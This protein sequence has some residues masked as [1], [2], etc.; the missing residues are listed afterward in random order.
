MDAMQDQLT[1]HLDL[2]SLNGFLALEPTLDL[3]EEMVVPA[4]WLP[5]S[6]ILGR[7]SS[8]QPNA[9][10]DDPLAQYKARRASARSQFEQREHH[11]NCQRLG[12]TE[13]Q[14]ARNF[15]A[16]QVHI[17]LLYVNQLDIDPR[18]Y[19]RGVYQAVFVQDKSLQTP[20]EVAELLQ[21][22][23]IDA[24]GIMDYLK[25]GQAAL[26]EL[27]ERLL[28]Q[29]IFDSPAYLYRGERYHGRQHLPLLRWYVEG[30]KGTPPV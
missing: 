21:V 5:V 2:S 6:G 16:E 27:Q 4:R 19:I 8:Q 14:G 30:S 26:S 29:G 20:D 17:G 7:L 11:R 22:L 12:I 1:I 28:E 15:D 25:V 13:E 24:A 3:V 18:D 23:G 9:A 10:T